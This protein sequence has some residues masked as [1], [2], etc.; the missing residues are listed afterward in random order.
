MTTVET[1]LNEETQIAQQMAADLRGRLSA[2]SIVNEDEAL[3]RRTTLRVGGTADLWVEPA[4]EKDLS[5][6]LAFAFEKSLPIMVIGRGSNLLVRDGGIR[7]V[8]IGLN[9]PHFLNVTVQGNR[10][11]CGA[12][13]RVKTVAVEARRHGVAGLEF[14]EGIPG[15]VGGALCM[16]AGA[17]GGA[18]LDAV[19][20]VRLLDSEGLAHVVAGTD[21]HAEYRSCPML[22]RHLAVEALLEGQ[23]GEIA[24]IEAR[25]K[26]FNK[27]R[28]ASQP[29]A[30]SAGCIFKNP[31]AIPA[32]QLVEE[33]GLKGTRV[34][35]AMVSFEHGNFIV[36]DGNASAADVLGLIKQIK[37][38]AMSERGIELQTEVQVVGEEAS[39]E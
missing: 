13:A 9:Q 32:G 2:V 27:R 33:L 1:T 12:G 35:G 17:H 4:D 25:M 26:A 19:V 22:K 14:L 39:R 34:G 29:A 3:A 37:Q 16:N 6:V 8:V 30:P 24:D 15:S 10:L 21:M 18:C 20:E 31:E 23:P 5:T 28:W 36:T 11:R 7:G 38:Q